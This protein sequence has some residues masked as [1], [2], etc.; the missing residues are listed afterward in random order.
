MS[1]SVCLSPEANADV[2]VIKEAKQQGVARAFCI[3]TGVHL[4]TIMRIPQLQSD[5][6]LEAIREA[7]FS[8]FEEPLK[9]ALEAFRSSVSFTCCRDSGPQRHCLPC[10]GLSGQG[11]LLEKSQAGC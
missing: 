9:Q 1:G 4:L 10:E 11:V 2:T 6:I 7:E 8:E 3:W 5:D